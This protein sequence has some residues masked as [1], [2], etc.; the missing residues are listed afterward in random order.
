[1]FFYCIIV[2]M[3]VDFYCDKQEFSCSYGRWD[4]IRITI[5]N[6]TF[7]YIKDEINNIGATLNN[8]DI[9]NYYVYKLKDLIKLNE[10]YK[11]NTEIGELSV[12]YFISSIDD[13]EQFIY[14]NILGIYV[15]CNKSDSDGYY[16]PGNSLDIICL[17]DLIKQYL[18]NSEVYS[19][20][21]VNENSVYNL[22]NESLQKK[23][24]VV[25]S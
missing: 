14:F 24:N 6:A 3:G 23:I 15:L 12:N 10:D 2:R 19:C 18:I 17:L 5:L 25:I 7:N 11:N 22:F 9:Y 13:V 20:I 8:N 4:I 21:Y 16:S 1:M